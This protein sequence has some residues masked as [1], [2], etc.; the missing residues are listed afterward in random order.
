MSEIEKW[1]IFWDTSN[2]SD[3]DKNFKKMKL[4]HFMFN[5]GKK[6]IKLCYRQTKII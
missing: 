5:F 3:K 2:K 4:K 6:F 1:P